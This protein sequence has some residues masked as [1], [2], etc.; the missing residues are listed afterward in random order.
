[1][2]SGLIAA[3]LVIL[4]GAGPTLNMSDYPYGTGLAAAALRAAV[5]EEVPVAPVAEVAPVP[6]RERSKID[7]QPR[8]SS[9]K[10]GSI[11]R[12][13]KKQTKKATR[14]ASGAS[15]TVKRPAAA[16]RPAAPCEAGTGTG[17]TARG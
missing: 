9:A 7:R 4:I 5:A 6:G 2:A 15:G 12:A 1:M 13:N 16:Y 11:E 14:P 10:Q 8:A 3:A 17:Q